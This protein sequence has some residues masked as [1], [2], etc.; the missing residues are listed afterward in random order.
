M[1]EI[2]KMKNG[3]LYLP[4]DDG[5]M[6]EQTKCLEKLYDYNLTRPGEAEKRAAMRPTTSS[7]SARH[8]TRHITQGS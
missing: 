1:Q 4:G 8:V 2:E 3:E 7:R 6:A 5:I